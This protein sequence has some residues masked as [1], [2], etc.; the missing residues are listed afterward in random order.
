MR[1]IDLFAGL[2]G[3]HLALR[4]L[5]HECVF[6][7]EV[8]D[9]LRQV[10]LRNFGMLPYD[11]IRTVEMRSIPDHDIL[12]AGFP[13]QP[14]SKAGYQ[15]GLWDPIGGTLFR[16]IVK[17]IHE[18]QPEYLILENVPN[19][20]RHRHGHT[21]STIRAAIED[22]GYELDTRR[23]SPHQFGIPQIRDRLYIVGR[24]GCLD[25]FTWPATPN[26]KPELSVRDVLETNPTDA[27]SIP[28]RVKHCVQVWQEFLDQFPQDSK[29]PSFPIWSMEFGATYPYE[30]KTPHSSRVRDLRQTTGSHGQPL[31]GWTRRQ[32]YE[33][34]PS[35]ARTT[36]EAFPKWKVQFIR[37]NRELYEENKAWIDKWL[38]KILDFP[39]SFQKFE[40]NCQ[41]EE[42]VIRHFVLQVR[43]SG[44]RVKRPTTA[45]SLVAMTS[46]QVPVVGWEDRYMTPTECKRLQSMDELEYLPEM[47]TKTYKALG[48]AVNVDVVELIARAI[49]PTTAADIDLEEIRL[50]L[51]LT[52]SQNPGQFP[53]QNLSPAGTYL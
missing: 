46:T 37:Q 20:E 10:Y 12:C 6:A 49:I 1:F 15:N 29:L 33:G 13:C 23:Y 31:I 27:Q 16:D 19:L 18:R 3:F 2:G 26:P 4:R 50:G 17:I 11:D 14:F 43:A 51:P 35:Y 47:R 21:W 52:L 34:L 8:D 32:V 53:S 24:R 22:E 48:N 7:S 41:G 25:G 44:L 30:E 5:G 38:P 28:D 40:W 36:D 42:R 9:T 45:P 39:S